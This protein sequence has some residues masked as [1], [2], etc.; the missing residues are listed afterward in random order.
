[1][2]G[3]PFPCQ[4]EAGSAQWIAKKWWDCDYDDASKNSSEFYNLPTTEKKD[5]VAQRVKDS[6]HTVA[7]V[8]GGFIGAFTGQYW[9]KCFSRSFISR[10]KRKKEFRFS[11]Y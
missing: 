4:K 2:R 7:F 10:R 9:Y 11:F 6:L 1:M 8:V 5:L 3:Y